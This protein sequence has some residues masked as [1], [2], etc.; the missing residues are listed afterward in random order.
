MSAKSNACVRVCAACA[1]VCVCVSLCVCAR[2]CAE[3]AC[4]CLCV[5]VCVRV[6]VCVCVCA[7]VRVCVCVCVCVHVSV[8]VRVCATLPA[9]FGNLATVRCINSLSCGS[10]KSTASSQAPSPT[11][12]RSFSQSRCESRTSGR[13]AWEVKNMNFRARKSRTSR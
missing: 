3:C 11:I 13:F 5:C 2:A 10:Q 6:C 7:C 4:V 9:P 12:T 1:C 8:C